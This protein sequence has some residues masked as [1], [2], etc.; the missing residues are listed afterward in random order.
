MTD[1]RDIDSHTV[2]LRFR[3]PVGGN[4]YFEPHVRYYTQ[5]HADFYRTSL[6]GTL[7]VPTFA[8]AD[9]RLGEFDAITLG[10]KYGRKT[11]AGNEWSTRLEFYSSSGNVPADRLVG[12]QGDRQI[13]PDLDAIIAQFT[14]RFDW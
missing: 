12:N 7:P 13:Y 2:D 8:S 11:E 5:S 1:D 9:Y 10:L 6:D 4:S 3:W 14:Y